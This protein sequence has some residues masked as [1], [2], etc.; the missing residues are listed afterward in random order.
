M[1]TRLRKTISISG[2]LLALLFI[3]FSA[4]ATDAARNPYEGMT[5]HKL[6]NNLDV[7]LAPGENAENVNVTIKV[8][9][10]PVVEGRD[11]LGVSHLLEHIVFRDSRFGSDQSYLQVI[12]EAG[13]LINAYVEQEETVYHAEIPAEKGEWLVA[14]MARMLFE[15][16][17]EDSEVDRAKTSVELETGEPSWLAGL[18][19]TDILTPVFH[20]Y[21]RK[22]EFWESEFGMA[23]PDY[24]P[25]EIKLSVRALTRDQLREHYHSYYRPSNMALFISGNFER[26]H[27]LSLVE[28]LFGRYPDRPGK[29]VPA[30]EPRPN[31]KP[32]QRVSPNP[33]GTS[34]IYAGTKVSAPTARD[35]VVLLV[36]MDYVAHRL[37]K[38]LR[39]RYGQTYTAQS[40]GEI[41]HGAGYAIVGFET[42]REEF[43]KNLDY[44]QSLME[45]E[46]RQGEFGDDEV[47]QALALSRGQH[48]ELADADAATLMQYAEDYYEFRQEF[49]VQE[50]PYDVITSLAA[51]EFRE[52]LSGLFRADSAYTVL[53]VPY[54]FTKVEYL[55]LLVISIVISL[56][57]FKRIF[58]RRL[59]E[60]CVRWTLKTT[61]TVTMFFSVVGILVLSV[62]L[63]HLVTAP[64]ERLVYAASWYNSPSLW[65][66]YLMGFFNTFILIGII[67]AMLAFFPRKLV[68]EGDNLVMKS[69]AFYLRRFRKSSVKAVR[70]MSVLAI[71]ASPRIWFSTR[72]R[73]FF[74]S[75]LLWRKGLLVEISGGPTYFLSLGNAAQAAS[76]LSR[77]LS[78]TAGDGER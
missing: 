3:I 74:Q 29:T 25:D 23:Y 59:D 41:Q 63:Q 32:F 39:N 52:S 71:M 10:G 78:S 28:S 72:F 53:Y 4:G 73:F 68:V 35:G 13:G 22:P 27:M 21:F 42:T 61:G 50:S 6:N 16:T 44:V 24:S 31:E 40:F 55:V 54:L 69:M 9:V 70:P 15:Q 51:D 67:I 2:I 26:R 7:V 20:R 65:P 12:K 77:H 36:Y 33:F 18:L 11:G 14:E 58:R 56:V 17:V 37:M 60:T 48:Y 75:L 46:A 49:G 47:A 8:K 19:G 76:D 1:V 57:V 64:L 45:K 66:M 5:F 38:E 30:W 62:L 43:R 34:Y